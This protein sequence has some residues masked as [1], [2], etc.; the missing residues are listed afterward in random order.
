[1]IIIIF[2][3]VKLGIKIYTYIKEEKR[4]QEENCSNC[5]SNSHNVNHNQNN[6]NNN[7]N[8]NNPHNWDNT[9]RNRD[10]VIEVASENPRSR[11]HN[12]N[13][14]RD[15]ERERRMIEMERIKKKKCVLKEHKHRKECFICKSAGEGKPNP[16]SGKDSKGLSLLY[17]GAFICDFCKGNFDESLKS[18]TYTRCLECNSF[19]VGYRKE[20][21][22]KDNNEMKEF[23]GQDVEIENCVICQEKAPLSIIPC[24]SFPH[25]RLHKSC[26]TDLLNNG[27]KECPI[28]RDKFN[29]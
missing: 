16:R 4:R 25:H 23:L 1:M 17:C 20:E 29:I 5:N 18:A 8:Y 12:H 15:P 27:I 7:N 2:F 22:F 28:C 3:S 6:N 9:N 11:L 21:I 19:M 26:L 24:G 10:G 14:D 13:R